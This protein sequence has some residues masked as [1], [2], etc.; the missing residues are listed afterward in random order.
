MLNVTDFL[1]VA[2]FFAIV[3]GIS[4]FMGRR[5]HSGED[6]FLAGRGLSWWI[7]GISLIAANISTEQFVGMNGG[8]AGGYGLAIASYDWVAAITLVVVAIFFLPILLRCGIYTIPEFLEYRF[9]AHARSIMS[10][11]M[12]VIYVGVTISAVLYSGGLAIQTIFGLPLAQ[13]VWVVGIIA[14]AYTSY[15]GLKSVAWADLFQGTSLIVGGLFVA[16]VGIQAVGGLDAFTT[17]NESHLHMFLPTDHPSLPWTAL[18]FGLWIPN[19]YYW[20][21][22]QYIAQRTLAARDLK[23]GQLGVLTAAGIQIILPLVIVVPGLIALQL[24]PAEVTSN[25]DTAFPML[26][27]KLV[28]PGM[29][30][31]IFAAIAGAIISSLASMLNSA[32]TIFTMDIFKRH[33]KPDANQKTIVAMGRAMTILFTI[34][35]CLI[36]P[37]L[38]RFQGIFNFM[39]D[40]QGYV[41]PGILAVF[42]F[43]FFIKKAGSLTAVTGLLLCPVAY[44]ILHLGTF[45]SICFLNKMAITFSAVVTAMTAATLIQPRTVIVPLPVNAHFDQQTEPV[46]KVIGTIIVVITA[47]LYVVFF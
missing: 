40:L 47:S 41:S 42:I 46:V 15:G 2:L 25:P 30:G 13:S 23:S 33:L 4:M 18:L 3:I 5:E 12:M 29:R 26:I 14:A 16:F 39:Q 45:D 36:A 35:G 43:G 20:G 21:F 44:G 32:S 24:Y 37:N 34:V 9:S 28:G 7:I 8:A 1:V 22:N 10:F 17:H 38:G 6:Y 31:F 27:S 19:F 11:Y